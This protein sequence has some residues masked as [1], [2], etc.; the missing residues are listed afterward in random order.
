MPNSIWFIQ[1]FM[2]QRKTLCSSVSPACSLH[3]P[4]IMRFVLDVFLSFVAQVNADF[5]G[6]ITEYQVN[7]TC[8]GTPSTPIQMVGKL[9]G[10]TYDITS[11]ESGKPTK[12]QK[13]RLTVTE[14]RS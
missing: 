11:P 1:G 4:R 9:T 5:D 13:E 10:G 7:D 14:V 2:L 12:F 3:S 6:T 8:Q